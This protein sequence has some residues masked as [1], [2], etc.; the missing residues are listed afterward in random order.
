ML[1][2]EGLIVLDKRTELLPYKPRP[3]I[4]REYLTDAELTA[5]AGGT[6]FLNAEV[7][8]NYFLITFKL[9]TTG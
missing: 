8:P 5:N 1:N 4:Q 6:L 9:H 3:F 7:Y 2:D